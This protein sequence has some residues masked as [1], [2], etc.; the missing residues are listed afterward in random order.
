MI[1]RLMAESQKYLDDANGDDQALLTRTRQ[2]HEGLIASIRAEI[3]N[4]TLAD[5]EHSRKQSFLEECESQLRTF[6]AAIQLITDA[7]D[8]RNGPQTNGRRRAFQREIKRLKSHLP[9]YARRD[10]IVDAVRDN[11]VLILKAD[12]GAGKSTQVVQYLV[13]AGLADHGRKTTT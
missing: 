10:E 9:I 2:Q 1:S 8:N 13:D 4:S 6:D 3:N 7:R 12:T 5:S 11:R